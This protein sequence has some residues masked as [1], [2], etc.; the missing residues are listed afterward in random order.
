MSK[1]HLQN[2]LS[3]EPFLYTCSNVRLLGH[4]IHRNETMAA[5]V[6][7]CCLVISNCGTVC[8]PLDAAVHLGLLCAWL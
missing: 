2:Q 7:Q 8:K 5:L 3:Y 4:A 1:Y 6:Y